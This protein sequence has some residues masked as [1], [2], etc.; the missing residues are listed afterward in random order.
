MSDEQNQKSGNRWE[1]AGQPDEPDDPRAQA[2][3]APVAVPEDAAAGTPGQWLRDRGN[4]S[5]AGLAGAAAL[6]LLGGG[7]GGFFVGHAAG[8]E[9]D[10][11]RDVPGVRG[12]D[13]LRE[14]GPRGDDD[15]R[16]VP[17]NG[18]P[19]A[20]HGTGQDDG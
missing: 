11:G 20:P 9:D 17:P 6:L 5:R 1:P 7:L 19:Q 10:H 13:G 15:G 2:A 18:Q 4:R 3:P 16:F 8:G 14:G 12:P